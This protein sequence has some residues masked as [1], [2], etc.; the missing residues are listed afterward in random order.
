MADIV[1]AEKAEFT[2]NETAAQHEHAA[3]VSVVVPEEDV[4]IFNAKTAIAFAALCG[5]FSSYVMTLLIPSTC[6]SYINADLGPDPNHTWITVS[7]QL[8]AAVVVSVGGRLSDIFG[9]RYFMLTGSLLGIVGCV[10][11][12]TGKSI[13]QMIGSG[14]IFGIASGFQEMSYACIQEILPNRYRMLGVGIFDSTLLV[15]YCSPLIAYTFIDH[16]SITWRAA[17]WYMFAYHSAM[18][19]LLLFCYFPPT[20]ERKHHDDGKTKSQLLGELDYVGLL[21]FA[22]ASTLMLLGINFGGGHKYPWTSA[23]VLAPIIVGFAC[24]VALSFWETMPFL[25]Y[26][27]LPPKLFRKVREFTMVI[28]LV[29]VGGMLY[30]SMNVLWPQQASIFFVR[31][32]QLILRGLYST[33]FSFGSFIGAIIMIVFCSRVGREKWQMFGFM[34]LQTAFIGAMASVGYSDRARA[35]VFVL[36]TSSCVTPPQLVAFTMISLGL[37]DQR[38][39]GVAAG[40]IGTF[41]LLGGAI[42]TAIYSAILNNKF[43]AVIGPNIDAVAEQYGLPSSSWAALV[44]AA[45]ANTAKAYAAVPGITDAIQAAAV[46]AYKQSYVES[47]RLVYLVAIAFGAVAV[48]AALFTR[49]TDSRRKNADR[50][51]YLMTEDLEPES[52]RVVA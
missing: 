24:A 49:N 9:R 52:K 47:F 11:G 39:I 21:L 10:V 36:L 32:D 12:A 22:T 8:G 46:D 35:I 50:A 31:S 34:V 23:T 13:N 26:P 28:V 37:D 27:L 5:Q 40:L 48:T 45:T 33:I 1:P 4:K 51:V 6:L 17:Y 30:Y 20:F 15:S 18:G 16:Y 19:L 29:F 41:R 44:T 25:K 14:I 2:A 3:S 43:S 7:W 42:A 38:D